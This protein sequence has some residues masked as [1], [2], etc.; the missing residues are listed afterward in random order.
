MASES[1][2][3]SFQLRLFWRRL[4]PFFRRE[5]RLY[6]PGVFFELLT[7][8]TAVIYPQ[9]IRIIVDQGIQTG[10]MQR[11]NELVLLM[12]GV[13]I[14]ASIATYMKSYLLDI[15]AQRV[16]M[17]LRKW[18][19]GNLIVQEMGFFDEQSTGEL[20]AR[21]D[22]DV[23]QL[24][25]TMRQL[26]PE[27]IHFS[28]LGSIAAGLMIYTAPLLSGV[29]L[30]VG[31]AIWIGSS[32]LGRFMRRQSA[33]VQERN[34]K[35][36]QAGLEALAGIQTVRVY[37]QEQAAVNR[38]AGASRSLIEAAKR[39]A[40]ATSLLQ[41]YTNLLSEGAVLLAIWVGAVLISGG[42]MTAG[43]LVTF[44]L[45]AAM[46]MRSVRNV[47][48]AAAEVMRAQGATQRIFAL[49]ER[50]T[51]MP[52]GGGHVPD[53]VE[54]HVR[55]EDVHFTY[56]TRPESAAL[57]GVSL[58]IPRGEVLAFVGASGSGKS[59]VA[60]LIA[61]LYDPDRGRI[62]LDGHDLCELDIAWL[63]E[64][65]TLV[66]AEAT[67]F[68]CNVADNIRYGRADATDEE[69]KEA[70]RIAHADEFIDRLPAGYE[71]DVGDSGR[72]FSSGQRQRIA[73]AR[74][75]LRRSRILILDEATAALDA[76]GEALVKESLRKLPDHPT[77]VIV[78]HRLSTILDADRVVLVR[79]GMMIAEGTHSELLNSSEPYRD[80]VENQLVSD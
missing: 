53:E 1:G 59:T 62:L 72:L 10:S 65:V 63:R 50:A 40:K 45:Y 33:R 14:I 20:M 39:Q 58:E 79:D 74:A 73:I 68:A 32:I 28:L 64:H 8:G 9:L 15:A 42:N 46:V 41:S 30:V 60:K 37:H 38:Y 77:I 25:F 51:Q 57:R 13:L 44:I 49:G 5:R 21:L 35:V 80:L 70:A 6:G 7:L 76:E 4:V 55:L 52:T 71:T 26:V 54:G 11:T 2:P 48:H 56:P 24:G 34:V 78:S 16:S 3:R 67:L 27:L 43:S 31:P 29:V 18:L 75:I 23:A 17:A 47:A 69:V 12:V 66:P 22:A 36:I 19:F 61:R